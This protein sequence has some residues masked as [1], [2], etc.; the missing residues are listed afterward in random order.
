MECE[1]CGSDSLLSE[2]LVGASS[3][4]LCNDCEKFGHRQKTQLTLRTHATH[5]NRPLSSATRGVDLE[6]P[7]LKQDY[8][9]VIQGEM[10]KREWNLEDLA[11]AVFEKRSVI[12]KIESGHLEPEDALVS[13]LEKTL[14]VKLRESL[15][16]A[17]EPEKAMA[18][19][20]SSSTGM[21]LEDLVV[22]KRKA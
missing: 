18:P 2:V 19:R 15:S 8:R 1:I 10:R 22:V 7:P 20:L 11:K 21:T 13:R 14:G 9:Q 6:F 3:L 16:S 5:A 4:M 17:A 12:A